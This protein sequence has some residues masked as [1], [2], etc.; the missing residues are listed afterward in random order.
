MQGHCFERN[1]VVVTFVINI[2][3]GS[4]SALMRHSTDAATK[5]RQLFSAGAEAD[6]PEN[7]DTFPDLATPRTESARPPTL[8]V[9][10]PTNN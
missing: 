6:Y 8:C 2:G 3:L 10:A 9:S 5:G 4:L 1:T 7:Q